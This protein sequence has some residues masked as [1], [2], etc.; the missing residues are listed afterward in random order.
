M[1]VSSSIS[2]IM[3]MIRSL[4]EAINSAGH[5]GPDWNLKGATEDLQAAYRQ[6]PLFVLHLALAMR[7]SPAP[8]SSKR[9]RSLA[10]AIRDKLLLVRT[11][12]R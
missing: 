2:S 6:C 1:L 9:W 5:R 4:A 11:L 7:C 8:T 10:M 3:V 12:I